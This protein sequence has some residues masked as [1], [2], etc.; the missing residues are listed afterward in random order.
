[1]TLDTT[2]PLASG[3]VGTACQPSCLSDRGATASR[4]SASGRDRTTCG[5]NCL[6]RA[7]LAGRGKALPYDIH[8][9]RVV[10][11]GYREVRRP[12][13]ACACFASFPVNPFQF[14]PNPWSFGSV[15]RTLY[16][17]QHSALTMSP[18]RAPLAPTFGPLSAAPISTS[19][20]PDAPP[21]GPIRIID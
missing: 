11:I 1:M 14:M 10:G 17:T 3:R 12:L 15:I 16:S 19:A 5:P 13:A 8:G 20:T 2:R 6:S 18:S 7:T 21:I 4:P 9:Y